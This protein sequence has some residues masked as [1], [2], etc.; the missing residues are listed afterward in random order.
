MESISE[1]LEVTE[2]G[3]AE[4]GKYWKGNYEAR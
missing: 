3:S 4:P 1:I 2:E